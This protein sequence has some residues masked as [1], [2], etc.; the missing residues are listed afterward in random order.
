MLRRSG[1]TPK[2]VEHYLED[3]FPSGSELDFDDDDSDK[4]PNY[5]NEIILDSSDS[6]FDIDDSNNKNDIVLPPISLETSIVSSS[7]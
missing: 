2:D 4:D 1:L 3:D 5:E 6:D 7:T